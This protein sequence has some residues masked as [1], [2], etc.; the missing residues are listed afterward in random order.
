LQHERLAQQELLEQM[1]QQTQAL[2]QEKQQLQANTAALAAR[3]AQL[4]ERIDFLLHEQEQVKLEH[5][6]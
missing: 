5:G 6:I 4:E 3:N 2:L 1:V